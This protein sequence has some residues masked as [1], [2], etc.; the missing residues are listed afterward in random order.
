MG[1]YRVERQ[2][3]MTT[4][5]VP[6]PTTDE[7]NKLEKAAW[8][9]NVDRV[10][11]WY[12][13]QRDQRDQRERDAKQLQWVLDNI[14]TIARRELRRLERAGASEI[15]SV[16]GDRWGHVLRLCEQAGCEGRG[17]LRDN[18]GPVDGD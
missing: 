3:V 18:G 13:D 4:T 1:I 17:V 11:V 6:E 9:A 7:I 12:R 10:L 8:D 5:T 2:G 14:F 15:E 16:S